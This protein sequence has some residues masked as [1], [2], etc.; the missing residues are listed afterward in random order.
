MGVVDDTTEEM[1][2]AGDVIGEVDQISGA[3][4]RIGEATRY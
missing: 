2:E 4:G 3:D 1:G